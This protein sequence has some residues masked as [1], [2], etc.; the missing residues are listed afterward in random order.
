MATISTFLSRQNMVHRNDLVSRLD[1][2]SPAVQQRVL[3][4][5]NSFIAKGK[6]PDVAL[7]NAYQV[8]DFNVMKQASVQSYMDVFLYLGILFLVCIPFILLVR[9]GK[10][11]KLDLGEAMH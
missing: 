4:L 7:K 9:R 11:K 3:G 10:K 2:N 8:L 5:Q 6:T 1:I